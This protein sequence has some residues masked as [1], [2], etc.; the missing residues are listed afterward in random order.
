[1]S[2][3][4]IKIIITNLQPLLLLVLLELKKEIILASAS[5]FVINQTI[6]KDNH[7]LPKEQQQYQTT[8]HIQK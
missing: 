7:S 2:K 5:L 6:Q 8:I 1:M 4:T 3:I